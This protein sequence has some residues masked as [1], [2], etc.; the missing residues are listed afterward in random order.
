MIRAGISAETVLLKLTIE[1][2]VPPLGKKVSSGCVPMRIRDALEQ[3]HVNTGD[4]FKLFSGDSWELTATVAK[5]TP[6]GAQVTAHTR[7]IPSYPKQIQPKLSIPKGL[8]A[9]MKSIPGI[10]RTMV[11]GRSLITNAVL[12]FVKEY[13]RRGRSPCL[14]EPAR[15]T[16][17]KVHEKATEEAQKHL[18]EAEKAQKKAMEDAAKQAEEAKA[19]HVKAMKLAM[20]Q[21]KEVKAAHEKPVVEALKQW[22]EV[23]AAHEK[24]MDVAQK[25]FQE[26]E[27]THQVMEEAQT[28]L[29]EMKAA[30]EKAMKQ[31]L[32]QLEEVKAAHE[33]ATEVALKQL[34]EEKTAQEAMKEAQK[35]LKEVKAAQQE[36]MEEALK[37]IEKANAAHEKAAQQAKKQAEEVNA[38]YEKA[39]EQ[40]RKQAEEVKA[41]QEASAKDHKARSESLET[42]EKFETV[43][44][45]L[46][47]KIVAAGASVNA[48]S[49]ANADFSPLHAMALASSAA[50]QL[51]Q[52]QMVAM[53][54][55]LVSLGADV[56]QVI[57]PGVRFVL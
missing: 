17:K 52:P 30:Y 53:A 48:R 26:A 15:E 4:S 32:K 11:P 54:E 9:V 57:G 12:E 33:K 45:Q 44:T 39:T 36:V 3:Q 1:G 2:N 8:N 25:R 28:Q 19:P 22:Q 47:G 43:T 50:W 31:A 56:D 41:V 6:D 27:A 24:A 29:E 35:Q 18:E 20:N 40:A 10:V 7:I 5:V 23:K 16:L 42:V 38:A 49:P 55:C 46:L 34:E 21:L 14:S 37:Q 13:E 51:C